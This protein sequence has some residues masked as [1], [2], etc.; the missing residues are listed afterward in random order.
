MKKDQTYLKTVMII[1]LPRSA[2]SMQFQE[3][4]RPGCFIRNFK[5]RMFI[6]LLIVLHENIPLGTEMYLID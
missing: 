1:T 3:P 4:S 2:S 5:Q 6:I